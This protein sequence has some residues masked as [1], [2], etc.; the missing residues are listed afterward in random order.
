MLQSDAGTKTW[1]IH[2]TH[3]TDS[4]P[5]H[6][7]W[8]QNRL[9]LAASSRAQGDEAAIL[10]RLAAVANSFDLSEP[11]VRIRE[12]IAEARASGGD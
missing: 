6:F 1:R 11:F 12:A 5:R 3:A 4:T 7:H 9:G 8:G 2:A 10:E